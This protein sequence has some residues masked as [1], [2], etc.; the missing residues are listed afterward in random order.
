MPC[1]TAVAPPWSG[2]SNFASNSERRRHPDP[3]LL[4]ELFELLDLAL[5]E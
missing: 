2:P 4:R 5:E 1:S 3:A